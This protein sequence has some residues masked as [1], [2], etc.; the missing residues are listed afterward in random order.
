MTVRVGDSVWYFAKNI[1]DGPR[2]S[3]VT[4]VITPSCVNLQVF[5]GARMYPAFSVTTTETTPA[6]HYWSVRDGESS[7]NPDGAAGPTS[8]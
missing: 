1:K 4:K 6:G 5:D 8:D 3:I 2:A 7:T